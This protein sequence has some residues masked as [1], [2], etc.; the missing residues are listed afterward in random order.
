MSVRIITDTSSEITQEEAKKYHVDVVPMYINFS[1]NV[2]KDGIDLSKDMFYERM[3]KDTPKTSQPSPSDFL[4]FFKNAAESKSDIVAVLLSSAL[5]GTCQSAELAAQMLGCRVYF[6]DSSTASY[7]QKI[8]LLEAI[9]LR[10]Q[11]KNAAEITEALT[12]L[13]KRV[14]IY[15]A[16]DTLEY[17]YKGGR[18]NVVEAGLGTLAN[19]KP[20]ITIKED[21]TVGVIGKSLG[22]T[23]A[24]KQIQK[25]VQDAG[26]DFSYPV[27]AVYSQ[28]RSHSREL[29]EKMGLTDVT[30]ANIGATIGTHI[31]P[32][33]FGLMFV[34]NN[35]PLQ[36]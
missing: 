26:I 16:L 6:K 36:S 21:G 18:L 15:A 33:A 11:G 25:K 8:L 20:I 4:P 3:L 30:Y 24:I 17:L 35:S 34:K 23:K 29:I 19:I 31:G 22:K 10:D 27:Y 2:L 13:K 32:G 28:D 5:S 7:A 14:V 9:K 12:A 1:Q